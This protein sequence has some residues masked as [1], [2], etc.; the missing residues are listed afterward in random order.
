[1]LFRSFRVGV[2]NAGS[3]APNL[4]VPGFRWIQGTDPSGARRLCEEVTSQGLGTCPS[5]P[6]D[7]ISPYAMPGDS[8]TPTLAAV[9]LHDIFRRRAAMGETNPERRFREGAQ[10]ITFHVTDEPGSNDWGRG[11]GSRT[12]PMTSMPWGSSYAVGLPNI[13]SYFRR[14]NILTFGLVPVSAPPCASARRWCAA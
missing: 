11:F 10:V 12:D 3:M 13:V 1:M 5:S 2:F 6:S 7:T 9:I 8:E 14:N 4:D